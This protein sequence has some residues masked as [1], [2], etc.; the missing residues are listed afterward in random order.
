MLLWTAGGEFITAGDNSLGDVDER[1][2]K[3]NP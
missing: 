1:V 2:D 3:K